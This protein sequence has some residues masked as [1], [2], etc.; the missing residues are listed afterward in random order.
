MSTMPS[1]LAELIGKPVNDI[2]TP[3]LVIDMDAMKRNLARMAEFAKKHNVRWRPHAKLHKSASL[4]KMQVRAGAVGVCVQKTSEAEIMAAGG[5]TDIY[6]SNEVIAPAK[7]ARVAALAQKL[8]AQGGHLA[9]AVDSTEGVI[10]LAQAM[11]EARSATGVATVIDVFVEI[12]VGQGRC[13]VEPGA[14]AVTLVLEIRKHPA[15]RFAGLQAY[16]GKAQHMRSAHER[17]DAIAKAVEAV[18]LTRKLVEAQGITVDLV[19]GAGTGSLMLEAASGVYG[20][21]QAGSFMFMDAD[22]AKNERD[23]AQPQFEHALFVKTQV[24]STHGG[25]AVCDAGHKSHAIDS[26]LPLVHAFDTES[27]LEFFNGG[28]EHGILRPAGDS[29][30]LPGLGRMLWL[31]P[32]H[33]DPTVNL[34]DFMIGVTGGLRNGTVQRI[35]RVDARGALT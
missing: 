32:G 16:H 17:R 6:I 28:D 35:F 1:R 10:R 4:A 5:V 22:Y 19:T 20:E 14:A 21:L 29:K 34:H 8:A 2:D 31:I 24:V 15:L 12:D 23:P 13:G 9:I 26:G 25:H 18:V 7:L 33:C 3:A 30:R 27:E 11:T